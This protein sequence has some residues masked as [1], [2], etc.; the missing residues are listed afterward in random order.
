MCFCLYQRVQ[1]EIHI[2]NS[3][4]KSKHFV[5][6]K[7]LGRINFFIHLPY[8]FSGGFGWWPYKLQLVLSYS[9]PSCFKILFLVPQEKFTELISIHLSYNLFNLLYGLGQEIASYGTF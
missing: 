2:L 1:A 4:L 5:I 7:D 3:N 8:Q 9:S 6:L